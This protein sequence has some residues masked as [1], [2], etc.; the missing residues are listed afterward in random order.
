VFE[1]KSWEEFSKKIFNIAGNPFF[2]ICR[3]L[4]L[5]ADAEIRRE[6]QSNLVKDFYKI[7]EEEYK[8][9]SNGRLKPNFTMEQVS[10]NLPD[11]S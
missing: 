4:V 6:I 9:Q 2:D 8:E 7:L 3:F 1:S 10:N 11:K 5:A